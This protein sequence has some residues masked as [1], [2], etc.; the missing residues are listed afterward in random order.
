MTK[1]EI[2]MLIGIVSQIITY[3]VTAKPELA[4]NALIKDMQMVIKGLKAVGL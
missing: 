1:L 3:A 2:D 4:D